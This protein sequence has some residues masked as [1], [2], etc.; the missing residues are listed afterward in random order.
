MYSQTLQT[1]SHGIFVTKLLATTVGLAVQYLFP[2][3]HGNTSIQVGKREEKARSTCSCLNY[4]VNQKQFKSHTYF[5]NYFFCI[6]PWGQF[7]QDH[8]SLSFHNSLGSNVGLCVN[9]QLSKDHV[10][11]SLH[12]SLGSNVGLCVNLQ[13]SQDHVSL[14]LHNSLGSNVGLCV[15]LQLS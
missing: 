9:L 15:N 10:S 8:V 6:K 14:S 11:L 13:L 7:S 12:N 4:T 1:F 5:I 3:N 2:F